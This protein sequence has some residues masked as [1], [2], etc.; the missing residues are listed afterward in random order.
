MDNRKL[1]QKGMIGNVEIKNRIVMAPMG[2]R[3]EGDGGA[4]PRETAYYV[5]RAKGG[6]GMIITGRYASTDKY[7]MRSHHLLTNFHHVGRLGLM[8]E[9]I[10]QYG[11]KL[12]LQIG[13]GLGRIVYQDPYTPPYSA[14]EVPSFFFPNLICKPYSVEQLKE[15]SWTMG[16]TALLARRAGVDAVEIHAY[17]GYLYDQFMST[18][19]NKRTDEYGGSLENRMRF[20]LETIEEIQ[21][22]AGEDFPIVVKYTPYH[23]GEPG[24]REIPEGIAIAKRLEEAGVAALHV[25]KGCYERWYEQITTVYSPDAC[26]VDMAAA[27]KANVNIPVISHGKLNKPEIAEAV[28]EE[29]KCDF[30]AMGHQM[31]SDPDYANKVKEGRTYDIRPCIGCNECVY[32]SHKGHDYSCAVNPRT[33]REE[34]YPIEEAEV[35]KRVLVIGGG[36][37]GLVTA[38]TAKMRGHDVELWEK[39]KELGGTLLSAG[40]PSFKRDMMAYK[41]Y[42]VG[43]A[44]RENVTIRLNKEA[45]PEAVAAGGFDKVILA[46]GAKPVVPPIPGIENAI[47]AKPVLENLQ[48][49]EGKKVVIIGG[50]LVGVETAVYAAETAE[51]VS[52]VEMLPEI[53]YQAKHNENN[54]QH[55]KKLVADAGVNCY[56]GAAVTNV[57]ENSLT[58]KK[59]DKET[60]LDCDVVILAA[61]YKPDKTLEHALEEADIDITVIGDAGKGTFLS[62]GKVWTAVHQGFYAARLV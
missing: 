22:Q 2:I 57:T 34:D 33:L 60:T 29:G 8:A 55:I 56:T 54:D 16:W 13:C 38:I 61:G 47:H 36:P 27:I 48:T 23:A 18:L 31:L 30:V 41:D 19:W 7:E 28:L 5:E 10:H 24:G 32:V 37:G 50:G 59:D 42:L 51:E 1:F 49:F 4:S 6:V 3:G 25:D 58:F 9:K 11:T 46:A 62:S 43:K 20:L 45:T 39:N 15:L 12:C 26:Q 52:V 53:L 14:S 44:Y 40:A 35:K 21:K 17:G